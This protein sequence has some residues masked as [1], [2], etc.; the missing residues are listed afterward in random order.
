MAAVVCM[1]MLVL[2]IALGAAAGPAVPP[3]LAALRPRPAALVLWPG[4][5]APPATAPAAVPPAAAAVPA[6]TPTPVDPFPSA[7]P[8]AP[9][10]P[11]DDVPA[12]DDVPAEDPA[13]SPYPRIGHVW[14]IALHG[15]GFDAA[16]TDDPT[17]PHW[18]A[19]DVRP[20]GALLRQAFSVARGTAPAGIALLS[21][22]GPN[23]ATL[24]GCQTYAP[25]APGSVDAADDMHQATGDGCVAP[26]TVTTLPDQLTG[27]GLT[28]KGYVESIAT[29]DVQACRHPADGA[30]DPGATTARPGDP[31]LTARNPFV[32]FA[33]IAG[34]AV[35]GSN[36]VGL[37]ALDAD[38]AEVDRTP[39]FS[40]IVPDA[41]HDGRDEPCAD[42]A[43]AGLAAAEA[44]LRPV[45]SKITNSPAY[46]RRGLVIIT[47]DEAPAPPPATPGGVTEPDACTCAPARWPNVPATTTVGGGRV[48]TLLLSPR[49]DAGSASDDPVDQITLLRTIE[50]LFGLAHIGAAD[51]PGRTSV[52]PGVF[53]RSRSVHRPD[54]AR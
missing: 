33:S 40:Y 45:L 3:S 8:L 24:A 1:A 16:W 50:D 35:C 31:Y 54:T 29:P 7:A 17:A 2:G 4:P 5:S 25:L 18:L 37:D 36:V 44:W 46:K 26:P 21:G 9:G 23:P 22:Q 12:A 39:A 41:C 51:A 38:L 30:A 28:W 52:D 15:V 34:D 48:G 53:R 43:P 42:G 6:P 19:H 47:S 49:I 13:P 11:V 27:A 20:Q 32:Y 10:T 14:V